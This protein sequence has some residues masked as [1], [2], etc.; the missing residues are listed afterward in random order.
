MTLAC[1]GR[2]N[3]FQE[4]GL[5][6]WVSGKEPACQCRRLGFDP[7]VRKIPWRREWLPTP[8]FLPRKFNGQ[9]SLAGYSPWTWLSTHTHMHTKGTIVAGM[10][11]CLSEARGHIAENVGLCVNPCV[12]NTD[13]NTPGTQQA[14]GLQ[15]TP[16][17]VYQSVCTSVRMCA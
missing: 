2:G 6:T 7:W 11:M 9:K 8:G 3:L 15:Y 5:P 14:Y 13:L 12:N 16:V 10:K 4:G 1:R 17:C